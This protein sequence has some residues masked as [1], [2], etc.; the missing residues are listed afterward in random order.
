MV[1]LF[2][3]QDYS[4]ARRDFVTA[5][6][7]DTLQYEP[8]LYLTWC[9]VG[10]GE[11]DSAVATMRR[12]HVL[13][14]TEPI[15]GARLSTVL[16][17]RGDSTEA[18]LRV[19]ELL[20]RDSLNGLA[21]AERLEVYDAAGRCDDAMREVRW[22][23]RVPNNLSQASIAYAW[24][25]CGQRARARKL[26]DSLAGPTGESGGFGAAVAYAGLRDSVRMF[27]ALNA[28]IDRHNALLFFLGRYYAFV[29]YHGSKAFDNV[30]A[31]AHVKG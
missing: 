5:I 7:L 22:V 21:H 3:H 25:M 19:N 1:E 2:G 6:R 31:R 17:L 26:A 30:L 14:P 13:A 27:A 11:M 29:R 16:M 18:L 24:A 23:A 20:R 10:L 12:A 15:V 28:A 4:S 8:W 9:H